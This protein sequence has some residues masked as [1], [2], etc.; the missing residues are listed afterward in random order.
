[1]LVPLFSFKSGEFLNKQIE[2]PQDIFNYPLRRDLIYRLY[3][4][5]VNLDKFTT[6][7]TRNRAETH[8]SGKKMRPQKGQGVARM[9][10]KR[11]PHLYKGG[12]AHGSKPKVY[13]F[14]L[15]AKIK[16]NALKALLSAKMTEG[17]IK[18][19]DS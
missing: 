15:N 9:G 12:K 18:I 3:N 2:L 17:K 6:K 5:R 7:K 10:E 1:M 19:V 8:G 13:S 11:A 4:Y 16:L 14:P